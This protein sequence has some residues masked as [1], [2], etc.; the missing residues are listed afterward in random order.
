M[1][2]S[3]PAAGAYAWLRLRLWPVI[4]ESALLSTERKRRADVHMM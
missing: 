2:A 4:W 1:L 3:D